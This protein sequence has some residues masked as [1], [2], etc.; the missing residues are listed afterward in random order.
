MAAVLLL[1]QAGTWLLAAVGALPFALAGETTM[2]ALA[3]LTMA[4]VALVLLLAAGLAGRRRWARSWTMA[5]EW[6]CLGGS[7][8]LL[9]LPIGTPRGL[10]ALMVDVGL[11]AALLVLLTGRRGRQAF[12]WSGAGRVSR[13][14]VAPP[15]R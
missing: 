10:V 4:L 2:L 7:L 1:V 13:R 11:P 9:L 15:R 14:E 6:V 12:G 8:L 3:V 5:L